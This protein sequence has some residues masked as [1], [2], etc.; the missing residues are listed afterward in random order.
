MINTYLLLCIYT[1]IKFWKLMKIINRI[2]K[3][4]NMGYLKI[5]Q[6]YQIA[7]MILASLS[8]KKKHFSDKILKMKLTNSW[9]DTNKL[10]I[11]DNFENK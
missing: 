4:I 5:S 7:K 10:S 6:I 1:T 2:Y 8:S 11:Q 3:S 9:I